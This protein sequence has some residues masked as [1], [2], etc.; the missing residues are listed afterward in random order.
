MVQKTVVSQERKLAGL[1]TWA[2]IGNVAT[3]IGQAVIVVAIVRVFGNHALGTY[4]L[5]MSIAA[6][7]FLCTQMQL[8]AVVATDAKNCFAFD[9]FWRLRV[10][11][12]AIAC[13]T[14]GLIALAFREASASLMLVLVGLLKS[15]EGLSDIGYGLLQKHERIGEI[16]LSKTIRALGTVSL[17]I[18]ALLLGG[19]LP[20]AVVAITVFG[21]CCF[22]GWDRWRIRQAL[23]EEPASS[24]VQAGDAWK[25]VLKLAAP[26]GVVALLTSLQTTVP[27]YVIDGTAD[28]QELGV[29][30]AI[31]YFCAVLAI[32][33]S[34]VMQSI[35]SRLARRWGANDVRA[36]RAAVNQTA[37]VGAVTSMMVIGFTAVF[38]GIALQTVYGAGYGEK[39]GILSLLVAAACIS[40]QSSL[41]ITA[42]QSMRRFGDIL[43]A[44][45]YGFVV[46]LFGSLVLIPALGIVGA[47][48]TAIFT[49]ATVFGRLLVGS[50]AG[51]YERRSQ[52]GVPSNA[53]P[54]ETL[55]RRGA[56]A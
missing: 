31:S 22:F 18:V 9:S 28:R 8:R 20:V 30:A 55:R 32:A 29:Y 33:T 11:T 2:I 52:A 13:L 42:L 35:G 53:V 19:S 41:L 5:A 3:A 47:A 1:F 24:G 54:A 16:G 25:S 7:I 27:R 10:R 50:R 21:Y 15:S 4:A 37:L 36:F 12:N 49:N 51:L 23:S 14:C 46:C 40:A 6:P 44:S 48:M 39:G 17:F 56:A 38:G 34:A 45:L 26:L 43:K